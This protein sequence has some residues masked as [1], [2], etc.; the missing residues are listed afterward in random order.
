MAAVGLLLLLIC[1]N[2][3]GLMLGRSEARRRELGIRRSLGASAVAIIRLALAEALV[4]SLAGFGAALLLA[5]AAAPW[6]ARHL[7]GTRP[8]AIDIVPDSRAVFFAAVICLFTALAV[9]LIPAI[10]ALRV[11]I[12]SMVSRGGPTFRTSRT[13]FVFVAVQVTLA[14]ILTIGGALLFRSLDHLRQADLGFNRDR[15]LIV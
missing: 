6:L 1:A 15:L 8:L 4:L 14:T 11:D 9:S 13:A 2:V 3:G 10:R 12:T 7:P 5:R